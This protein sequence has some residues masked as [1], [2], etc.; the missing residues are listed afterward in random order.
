MKALLVIDV[1]KSYLK[2]YEIDLLKRINKQI[3][4]AQKKHYDIVYIKNTKKLRNRVITDEL[5]DGL[6][7]VSNN[8]FCK[9]QADAFTSD[10]LIE[11]LRSRKI[12][13]VELIGID[14][15]SCIS[16]SAKGAM[17]E[18]FHVSIILNCVGSANAERFERTK[19][20]LV[21]IGISFK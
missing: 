16:A 5:S 3:D 9:E 18:R 4:A 10:E 2:K 7:I 15:N 13:E 19:E 17:K 1:Q 21:K 12:S 14:G 20:K 6:M 11:Y 8:V